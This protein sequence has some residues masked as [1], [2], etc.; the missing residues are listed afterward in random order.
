MKLATLTEDGWPVV[1][2]VWYDYDGE[3][4]LV[5]GRRKAAWVANIQ[6]DPRV[7]VCIDTSDAP[8][9]RVLVKAEADVVDMQWRGDWES[10]AIRYR[11]EEAGRRYFQET[12][13]IPRA[14]I[15]IAPLEITTWAGPGW[16]PR[17][18]E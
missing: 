3:A 14:L 11:G 12:R 8:Y 2:P 7:A 4:F 18:L 16:H 5:G 13:H 6:R 17:Y 9:T 10:W 1:N 15:R